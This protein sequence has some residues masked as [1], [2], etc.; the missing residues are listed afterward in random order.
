MQKCL[1]IIFKNLVAN[2]VEA[3]LDIFM[4]SFSI[5][6]FLINFGKQEKKKPSGYLCQHVYFKQVFR[7]QYL[8]DR[9]PYI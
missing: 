2:S 8:Q 1:K 3:K 6:C 4:Q 9:K 7:N 5:L